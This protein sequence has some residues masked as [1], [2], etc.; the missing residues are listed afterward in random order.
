MRW[1]LV[2]QDVFLFCFVFKQILLSLQFLRPLL[3]TLDMPKSGVE[4]CHSSLCQWLLVKDTSSLSVGIRETIYRNNAI[5]I[6]C[7]LGKE[8]MLSFAIWSMIAEYSACI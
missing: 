8:S 5:L 2:P 1:Y 7:G 6:R 4:Y 3:H